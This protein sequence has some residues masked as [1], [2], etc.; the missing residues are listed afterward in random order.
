MTPAGR[1]IDEPRFGGRV[2]FAVTGAQSGGR[3][4]S[5]VS[6]L[7]RR[8]PS[9]PLHVHPGQTER[10]AVRRGSLSVTRAGRVHVLGPGDALEVAPGTPH[11][12]APVGHGE[13]E[14]RVDFSPAGD[15]E[16]FLERMAALVRDDGLTAT[17]RP[18]VLPLAAIARDHRD[19]VRLARVPARVQDVA[20]AV[21]TAW[22]AR[23]VGRSAACGAAGA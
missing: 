7:D 5:T 16:G 1:T 4:L 2:T 19:D 11:S 3:L 21:L 17:G 12:F 18:R 23:W 8:F 13:V 10:F 14:V 15:M 9:V 22:P 20:L 6:V